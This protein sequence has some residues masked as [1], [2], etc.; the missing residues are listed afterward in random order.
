MAYLRI[1]IFRHFETSGDWCPRK[2]YP[3]VLQAVGREDCGRIPVIFSGTKQ[4]SGVLPA[5]ADSG[6]YEHCL[7]NMH[8]GA[9]Y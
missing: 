5:T 2:H 8:A 7:R 4:R 3:Q 9:W 1:P 6:G